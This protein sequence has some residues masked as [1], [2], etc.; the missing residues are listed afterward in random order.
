MTKTSRLLPKYTITKQI[1]FNAI[2]DSGRIRDIYY[3]LY[4]DCG[5]NKQNLINV[6]KLW[7][8]SDGDIATIVDIVVE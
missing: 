2:N 4:E 3:K 6:L 8:I 1:V 7:G 5:S